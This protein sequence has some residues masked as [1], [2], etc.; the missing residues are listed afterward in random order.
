MI[1]RSFR[2][3]IDA[4]GQVRQVL[5]VHGDEQA[6]GA[7]TLSTVL[8]GSG[9]GR[10]VPS[11]R[12]PRASALGPF[13][14]QEPRCA[15][16]A[17]IAR[18]ATWR[19]S[20]RL[21]GRR[22]PPP[23][24]ECHVRQCSV[25][26]HHGQGPSGPGPTGR[27]DGSRLTGR[28]SAHPD[29]AAPAPSPAGTSRHLV[30]EKRPR[31]RFVRRD[32]AIT[33]RGGPPRSFRAGISHLEEAG[34]LTRH[35]RPTPNRRTQPCSIAFWDLRASVLTAPQPVLGRQERLDHLADRRTRAR[36][37]GRFRRRTPGNPSGMARAPTD[38]RPACGRDGSQ[39]RGARRGAAVDG[40]VKSGRGAHPK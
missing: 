13:D 8:R 10:K 9:P 22:A 3:R 32:R 30:H 31:P 23:T 19:R 29:A 18:S 34:L 40:R 25:A 24:P 37:V 16:V 17:R 14:Q 39:S 7:S 33:S 35:R 12:R 38:R 21:R 36:S 11:V 15:P 26:G 4:P 28:T 1:E 6:L 5:R 20:S 2:S 27:D